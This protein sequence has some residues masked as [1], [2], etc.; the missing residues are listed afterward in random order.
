MTL[1]TLFTISGKKEQMDLPFKSQ[2]AAQKKSPGLNRSFPELFVRM[3]CF[4]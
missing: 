3:I 1:Q 2:D 4:R